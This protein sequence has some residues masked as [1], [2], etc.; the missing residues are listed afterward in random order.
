MT[1]W[2]KVS[3]LI[4]KQKELVS[5]ENNSKSV[6]WDTCQENHTCNSNICNLVSWYTKYCTDRVYWSQQFPEPHLPT[7][8]PVNFFQIIKKW[9]SR[10]IVNNWFITFKSGN[11]NPLPTYPWKLFPFHFANSSSRFLKG[12]LSLSP[13]ASSLETMQKPYLVKTIDELL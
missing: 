7:H 9:R 1:I 13:L 8:P 11:K 6:S 2:S 10:A 4:A 3:P 12:S 5:M